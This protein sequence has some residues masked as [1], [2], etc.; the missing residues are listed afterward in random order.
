MTSQ[1]TFLP[2]DGVGPEV[3]RAILDFFALPTTERF[4]EHA[5]AAGR[6]GGEAHSLPCSFQVVEGGAV[7]RIPLARAAI[8]APAIW[9]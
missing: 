3:A 4:L 8:A 5:R 6:N 2:G 9:S 1:I 7:T